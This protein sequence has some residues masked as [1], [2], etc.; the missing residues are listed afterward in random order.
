MLTF[1]L[2]PSPNTFGKDID[3]FLRPLVNELKELWDEGVV[4]RDV[5]L[6]TSFQMRVVLLMTVNDFPTYSSLSG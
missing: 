4:V 1:M 5:T 6:K 3:V 2:I